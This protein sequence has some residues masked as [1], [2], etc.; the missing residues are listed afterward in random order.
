MAQKEPKKLTE[1]EAIVMNAVWDLSP[2]TVRDVQ[3]HLKE[4]RPMAYNTVLTVMRILRDKGFL[5]SHREGRVDV[6]EPAVSREHVGRRSLSELLE[7]FFSGSAEALVSQLLELEDLKA[8]D[9]RAIRRE[10]DKELRRR[11]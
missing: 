10:V 3:E 9:V 1:L 8:D 4:T 2:T 7:R 11:A 5:R 6:Y